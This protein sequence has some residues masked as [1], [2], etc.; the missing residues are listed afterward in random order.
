[1]TFDIILFKKNLIQVFSDVVII[2]FYIDFNQSLIHHRLPI[3]KYITIKQ[4]DD[5]RNFAY[6]SE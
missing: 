6:N 1:M 5:E 4:L 2:K 3:Y